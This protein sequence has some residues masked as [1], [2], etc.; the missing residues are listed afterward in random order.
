MTFYVVR[1]FLV[2]YFIVSNLFLTDSATQF[3]ATVDDFQSACLFRPK[4]FSP[5]ST[6]K[7]AE[8]RLK[9]CLV[10]KLAS[11]KFRNLEIT[12]GILAKV[13]CPTG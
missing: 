6:S 9:Q 13:C 8:Q 10:Y 7:V 1:I 5:V 11:G 3:S 4:M 2:Q 12:D